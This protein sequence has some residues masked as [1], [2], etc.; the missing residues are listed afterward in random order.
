[1]SISILLT[2]QTSVIDEQQQHNIKI[3]FK[4]IIFIYCRRLQ[5]FLIERA[6]IVIMGRFRMV[7]LSELASFLQVLTRGCIALKVFLPKTCKFLQVNHSTYKLSIR[8][9][10]HT[11]HTH[12]KHTH[13]RT[14][15]KTHAHTHTHALNRKKTL[16]DM[17][18]NGFLENIESGKK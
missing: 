4:N 15:S 13:A 18:V 5:H 14:H 2:T 17:N 1:M 16:Q 7:N 9:H 10:T 11:N 3:L 6:A 12:T 8:T